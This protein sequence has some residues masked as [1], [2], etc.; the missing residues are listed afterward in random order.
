MKRSTNATNE[1][2]TTDDAALLKA[3][4]KAQHE[5][6][7]FTE[8]FQTVTAV[9]GTIEVLYQMIRPTG[10]AP[11]DVNWTVVA[12]LLDDARR[13]LGDVYCGLSELRQFEQVSDEAT[14]RG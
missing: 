1:A 3:A 2:L 10:D 4:R 8:M 11:D 9:N 14:S 13:R 5:G 7:S 12:D 6:G